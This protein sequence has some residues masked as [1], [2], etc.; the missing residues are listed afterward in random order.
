MSEKLLRILLGELSTVRIRCRGPHCRTIT[1]MPLTELA[2]KKPDEL[3]KCPHCG[4]DFDPLKTARNPLVDFARMAE[5]IL[6]RANCY[7]VQF[8]LPERE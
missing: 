4:H 7:E 2:D 5:E 8:T 1:E 6:E 3:L